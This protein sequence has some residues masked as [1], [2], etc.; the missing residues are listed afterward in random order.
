MCSAGVEEVVYSC[1][2]LVPECVLCELCPGVGSVR[3][4]RENEGVSWGVCS[5]GRGVWRVV[6]V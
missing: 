6:S 1:L 4:C 2:F 5:C 3:E